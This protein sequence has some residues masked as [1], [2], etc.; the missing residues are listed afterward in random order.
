MEFRILG[1]LEV[2][3][4][5]RRLTLGGAA[6]SGAAGS[7]CSPDEPGHVERIGSMEDLWGAR[8]AADAANPVRTT[9][10]SFA[11]CSARTR[12]ATAI[13]GLRAVGRGELDHR[14]FEVSRRLSRRG[15]E[16][17]EVC[18]RRSRCGGPAA[19]RPRVRVVCAGGNRPSGS[20]RI[21]L[22]RRV[23]A[24][25]G[26][27]VCRGRGARKLTAEHP[28]RERLRGQLMLA[29]YR[30]GRQAEALATYQA[31]MES[32]V[33]ELGIEPSSALQELERAILRQD[34]SLD[35]DG[36]AE[37]PDARSWSSRRSQRRRGAARARRASCPDDRRGS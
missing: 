35:A 24:D 6:A 31:A 19:G 9:C 33:E 30:S 29:L 10:R 22:E 16:A 12:I 28:L 15:T 8:S 7:C 17:G 18:E 13:A 14:R 37:A 25:L 4:D 36:E 5:G 11:S 26:P 32:L 3:V 21:A 20:R 2:I 34:P 23:D 27:D 1:P